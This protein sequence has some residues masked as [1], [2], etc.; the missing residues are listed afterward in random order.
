MVTFF[1]SRTAP[2]N[3][4]V[5]TGSRENDK[6]ILFRDQ[7]APNGLDGYSRLTFYNIKESGFD[8]VGE[9]VSL[10]E[11]IVFPFRKI[12]CMKTEE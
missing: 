11:K 3:P 10:D 8:W 4:S 6:I 7:K 9:W 12:H 2:E 5:W 1:D